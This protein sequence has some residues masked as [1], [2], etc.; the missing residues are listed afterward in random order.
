MNEEAKQALLLKYKDILDD[1]DNHDDN[2]YPF[3]DII[4]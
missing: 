2:N 4:M 3:G 1:S